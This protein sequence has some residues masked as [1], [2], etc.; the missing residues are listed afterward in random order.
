MSKLNNSIPNFFNKE[1]SKSIIKTYQEIHNDPDHD[2]GIRYIVIDEPSDGWINALSSS[3]IISLCEYTKVQL[4]RKS[5]GRVHFKILDGHIMP[6]HEAIIT[7]YEVSKYM[8][9][10]TR[11]QGIHI[12]VENTKNREKFYSSVREKEFI[13]HIGIIQY[14]N[15]SIKCSLIT[16]GNQNIK[17]LPSGEYDILAPSQPYSS[18]KIENYRIDSDKGQ[19]ERVWFSIDNAQSGR[20]LHMGHVSRGSLTVLDINAWESLYKELIRNRIDGND[21]GEVGGGKYIGKI[22]LK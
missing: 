7:E 8:K 17:T 4:L 22:T 12:V 6:G 3:G 15:I 11:H 5:N 1:K 2:D 13:Q 21:T 10:T 18:M 9:R 16:E 19:F 14:N 20:H